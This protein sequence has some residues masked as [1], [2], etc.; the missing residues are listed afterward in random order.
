MTKKR[1][2]IPIEDTWKLEDMVADRE[3]WE[4]LYKEAARRYWPKEAFC[5]NSRWKRTS[6]TRIIWTG[7]GS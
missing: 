4:Q 7:C 1:Y 3:T 5:W 6:A 2:E